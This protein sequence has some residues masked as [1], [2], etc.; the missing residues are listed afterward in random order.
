MGWAI[1]C[2]GG[3]ERLVHIEDQAELEV[4]ACRK[5]DWY[6]IVCSLIP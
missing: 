3:A 2:N 6:H 4:D 1:A 5:S